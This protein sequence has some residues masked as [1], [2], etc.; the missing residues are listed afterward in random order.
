MLF[1]KF[2]RVFA[3]IIFYQLKGLEIE[4]FDLKFYFFNILVPMC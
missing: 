1:H 4:W 3:T 2:S